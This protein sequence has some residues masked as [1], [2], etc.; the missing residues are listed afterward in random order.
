MMAAVCPEC[1]REIRIWKP[2]KRIGCEVCPFV[3]DVTD[4]EYELM[5][6]YFKDCETAKGRYPPF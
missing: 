2:F 3:F 5:Q 1:K 6:N 4:D